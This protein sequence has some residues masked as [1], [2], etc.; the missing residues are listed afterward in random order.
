MRRIPIISIFGR[1]NV[2]K[3][4]L[5]N[6]IVGRRQ[7]VTSHTSG[8]TRDRVIEGAS[9]GKNE[10]L[11]VDTAGFLA[12]SFSLE[13]EEIEKAAQE[14]IRE[15][16]EGSDVVLFVVD[17]KAELTEQDKAAARFIRKFFKKVILVFNKADS[18]ELEN[19]S[20]NI[21]KIGFDS[22]IAVSAVS[23][24]RIGNLLD[25]ATKDFKIAAET[26]NKLPTLAIIGRPNVGKSTLFNL[27]TKSKRT[28]I[29]DIPGTTRD[30][31]KMAINLEKQGSVLKCML[32][33]T[34]G[35]R[36]RGKI[37]KG[38]EKFSVIRTIETVRASDIVLLVADISEGFTRGD[39]HLAQFVIDSGKKL[40][41]VLNKMDLCDDEAKNIFRFKFI[42]DQVRVAI[43]A[44]NKS[45]IGLLLKEIVKGISSV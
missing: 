3:S 23:G 25:L 13:E 22:A 37:Q 11:V 12:E 8:T 2:G 30:A 42:N 31:I 24:R 33:D 26:K 28:I 18:E 20:K 5:F 29:S 36:R 40:I 39:A 19:K 16:I 27:L 17:A 41:I 32:I 45:N 44:K 35:F 1:P 9:W 15:A 6:R 34:A 7:A 4:T 43:S 14:Q 38:I 21:N 10:F